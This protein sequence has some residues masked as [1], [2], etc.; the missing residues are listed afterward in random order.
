MVVYIHVAVW[1]S[2]RKSDCSV[3]LGVAWGLAMFASFSS[4]D[5]YY[6]AK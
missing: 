4:M 2:G 5:I 6:T 1:K 3:T